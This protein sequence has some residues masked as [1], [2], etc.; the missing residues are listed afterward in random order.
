M[1]AFFESREDTLY[2]GRMTSYPFPLHVHED[3][4]IA[5]VLSGSCTVQLDGK[6]YQLQEG[7]L[8]IAFPL[9][10][11]SFDALSDGCRGFAALFLPDTI[12]EF[13]HTFHTLLPDEPVISLSA[14]SEDVRGLIHELMATPIEVYSP[15]RL[16]YLHLLLAHVISAMRF[17]SAEAGNERSV[18]ARAIQYIYEH[19]CENITLNSASYDLGI[20]KSH[21]SHL[22]SQQFHINFR[23]FINAIRI[24]KAIMQMRDPTITLTQICYGCGYENMRTFRRAFIQE[25]GVLPSDYMRQLRLPTTTE[26]GS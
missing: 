9:V 13:S 12:A 8:A 24:N 22:F 18:A 16:A 7:D 15:F 10:P 3:V 17:H 11:H 20:S 23:H 25:V 4:E 21:L 26:K 14:L 1:Q 19:A 2:V 5:C 6:T